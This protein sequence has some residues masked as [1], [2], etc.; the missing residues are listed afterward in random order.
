MDQKNTGMIKNETVLEKLKFVLSD[1][2][3]VIRPIA[4]AFL[5][6]PFSSEYYLN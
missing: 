3:K 6:D 2:L 1:S 4:S 5:L